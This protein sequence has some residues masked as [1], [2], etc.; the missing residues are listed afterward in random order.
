MVL[1]NYTVLTAPRGQYHD[2]KVTYVQVPQH[3]AIP[4]TALCAACGSGS[5]AQR[6]ANLGSPRLVVAQ[7][8]SEQLLGQNRWDELLD[9]SSPCRT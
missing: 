6:R 9:P 5:E 2:S 4:R 7:E 1:L 8:P 3:E